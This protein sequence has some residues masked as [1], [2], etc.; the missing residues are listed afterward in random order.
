MGSVD[1]SEFE[2]TEPGL[3]GFRHRISGYPSQG[4]RYDIIKDRDTRGD[5][6]PMP[7]HMLGGT[8]LNPDERD[9]VR[10]MAFNRPLDR[11]YDLTSSPIIQFGVVVG[12]VALIGWSYSRLQG[13]S[14]YA[15]MTLGV[16]ILSELGRKAFQQKS[17]TFP[18]IKQAF[19][20]M[21]SRMKLS[22]LEFIDKSALLKEYKQQTRLNQWIK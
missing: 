7:P 16:G 3:P 17:E 2:F 20:K 18:S 12:S 10:D 14:R 6:G 9:L 15:T 19:E 4:T 21:Q 11:I 1:I 8:P 5:M 13:R 22:I